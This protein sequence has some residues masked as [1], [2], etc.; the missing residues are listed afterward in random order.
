MPS[1]KKSRPIA[2][3]RHSLTVEVFEPEFKLS[4]SLRFINVDALSKSARAE[5]PIGEVDGGCC[6]HTVYATIR[7]G[8]V[9]GIRAEERPKEARMTLTREDRKSTRLNSSHLVI[10]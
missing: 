3:F 8:M 4:P 1:S 6:Q 2:I 10:S 5:I 7:K 9:V